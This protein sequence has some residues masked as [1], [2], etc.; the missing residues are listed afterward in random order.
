[1]EW[2]SKDVK[3]QIIEQITKYAPNLLKLMEYRFLYSPFGIE[4]RVAMPDKS[5]HHID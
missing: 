3:N 4:E 1:M 2:A 5:M